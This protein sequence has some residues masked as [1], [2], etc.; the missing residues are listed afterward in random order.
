MNRSS[1]D[2]ENLVLNLKKFFPMA[3]LKEVLE[4]NKL[5]IQENKQILKAFKK[6]QLN[7]LKE[8]GI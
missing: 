7:W 3:D 8:S 5:E 6:G 1:K 4:E 2:R